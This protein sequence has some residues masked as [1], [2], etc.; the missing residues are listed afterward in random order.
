[1]TRATGTD[2]TVHARPQIGHYPAHQQVPDWIV[3]AAHDMG[4]TPK[5]AKQRTFWAKRW[6]KTFLT[7]M[8]LHG[9]QGLAEGWLTEFEAVL[10]RDILTI[11]A[12]FRAVSQ[13]DAS[14]DVA[15]D[16]YLADRTPES[17]S[18]VERETV[19]EIVSKLALLRSIK[20]LKQ[21]GK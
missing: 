4:C 18:L 8:T 3:A 15:R 9:N 20:A 2:A 19:K 13:P 11:T 5:T 21:E 7:Q 17:L 10:G 12:A 14:E 1:M 6:V 16:T